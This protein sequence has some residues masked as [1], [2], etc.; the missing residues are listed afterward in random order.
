MKLGLGWR[1]ELSD[2]EVY[3]ASELF[4]YLHHLSEFVVSV[5]QLALR[6]S[7]LLLVVDLGSDSVEIAAF[8]VLSCEL[9]NRR[10]VLLALLRYG[11]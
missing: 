5:T 8:K 4:L 6:L 3:R 2:T 11:F 7:C 10:H 1:A 9:V